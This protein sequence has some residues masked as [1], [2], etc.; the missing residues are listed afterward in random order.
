M[1]C[2]HGGLRSDRS[3]YAGKLNGRDVWV[4]AAERVG[5]WAVFGPEGA[6]LSGGTSR[7]DGK[8][9]TDAQVSHARAAE[10]VA[11]QFCRSLPPVDG[12][13]WHMPALNELR[14]LV[15]TLGA[16]EFQTGEVYHS[17]TEAPTGVQVFG[18][19]LTMSNLAMSKATATTG[20]TRCIRYGG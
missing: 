14:F 10:N 8:A 17:S 4:S 7:D 19:W 11:S 12:Q 2:R 6:F 3:P 18:T 16:G 1:V 5:A 15:G 13:A 20:R 9:N